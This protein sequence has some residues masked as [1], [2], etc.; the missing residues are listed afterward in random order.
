MSKGSDAMQDVHAKL[1]WAEKHRDDMMNLLVDYAK[2]DGGAERPL[3][4]EFVDRGPGQLDARFIAEKP[5]P[6]AVS[7]HAADCNHNTRTALDHVLAR[8]KNH[9]GGDPGRGSFPTWQTQALWDAQVT[10]AKRGSLDGLD[11]QAVAL[12]YAEQPLHQ[13]PPDE[14]PLVVLNGLDND[15]KHRLLHPTFA[16]PAAKRALD[17]IEV[18]DRKLLVKEE[19]VWEAG[20][21]LEHGTVMARYRFRGDAQSLFRVDPAAKIGFSTGPLGGARVT[22]DDMMLRVRDIATKTAALIDSLP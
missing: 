8:L 18:R 14:D 10:T 3:R 21:P 2:P 4:V 13:I 17:V 9:F 11:A 6:A 12:I 7:L 5:V 22:Y 16:Y 19:N 15:D 1:D 20:Q